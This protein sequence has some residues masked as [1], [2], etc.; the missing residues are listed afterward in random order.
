[1]PK[2]TQKR[3]GEITWSGTRSQKSRT[4]KPAGKRDASQSGRRRLQWLAVVVVVLVALLGVVAARSILAQP[5]PASPV[6]IAATTPLPTPQV[7]P[8]EH[9]WL[10]QPLDRTALRDFPDRTYLFGTSKNN[11]YRVHHGVDIVNPTGTPVHAAAD[12]V[13]V[14]AGKDA[15]TRFG[16]AT[17]PNFYGNLVLVKLPQQFRGQDVYYLYGH[18]DQVLVKEGQEVKQGDIVGKVGMTGTADGPHVHVEVRIGDTKYSNSHNPALWLQ[19]LPGTG[20]LVGKVT[21]RSGAPVEGASVTIL[22][23]I[24]ASDAQ[25]YWGDLTTYVDDPL[26]QLNSDEAWGENFAVVDLP[27]GEYEIRVNIGGQTYVRKVVIVDGQSTWLE[28]QEGMPIEL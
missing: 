4:A 8:R 24:T 7:D 19:T 6:A 10:G 1:M 12:G 18:F 5:S 2:A 16:P 9:R 27:V 15:G 17:I 23:D 22:K 20:A 25:K 3:P 21:D 11:A 26:G 14:Y 28:V 13:V